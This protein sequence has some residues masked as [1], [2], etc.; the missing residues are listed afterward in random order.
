MPPSTEE[1][2]AEAEERDREEEKQKMYKEIDKIDEEARMQESAIDFI[3]NMC[4]PYG[5]HRLQGTRALYR[6]DMSPNG[7]AILR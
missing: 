4:F 2:D 1:Q 7:G 3:L 5:K 6:P